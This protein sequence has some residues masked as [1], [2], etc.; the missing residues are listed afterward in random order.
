[1]QARVTGWQQAQRN[2]QD[3]LSVA[4]VAEGAFSTLG[5]LIGR[6]RELAIQSANGVYTDVERQALQDEV[7]ALREQVYQVVDGT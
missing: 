6:I 7:V 5:G 2:I 1:M 4:N 3:G